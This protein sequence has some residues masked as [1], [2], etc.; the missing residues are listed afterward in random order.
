M[1]YKFTF[2]VFTPAFNNAHK[3]NRA[4]E[5]L[6]MQTFK[7]FEWLIVDDGSTDNTSEMIKK[8]QD[9]VHFP[10]HYIRQENRGKHIATNVGVE[11]AQGEFFVS[12]DS[13]DALPPNALERYKYYWDSIPIEQKHRYFQVTALAMHSTGG[14]ATDKY[15]L[16]VMDSHSLEMIYKY[17]IKGSIGHGCARTEILRMFPYPTDLKTKFVPEGLV[18]HA[19]AQAG[20]LERCVNEGLYIFYDDQDNHRLT[21]QSPMKFADS[22]ALWHRL[23]LNTEIKEWFLSAP[24]KITESS[25]HYT[26]FSL[27]SGKGLLEQYKAL[28]NIFAKLLWLIGLPIGLTVY[29]KDIMIYKYLEILLKQRYPVRFL[30]SR[31][32]RAIR[33]S[34]FFI[35][36]RNNYIL[37]FYS[38]AQSAAL[39]VDSSLYKDDILFYQNYLRDGDTVIDAG[40]NI[41]LLTLEASS[42][43]K[44]NGKVYAIE[45]HPRTYSYL[46]GNI[47]L[48]QKSNIVSFNYAVGDRNGK[49]LFQ[50]S[51]RHDDTNGITDSNQGIQVLIKRLDDLPIIESKI[52]LLKIDVE[53]YEL[54]VLRGGKKL[55]ERTACIYFESWE[56][57]FSKYHYTC[58]DLFTF[59]LE[60]KFKIFKIKDDNRLKQIGVEYVST[61]CENLIAIKDTKSFA[62]HTKLRLL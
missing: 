16:D 39:W 33:I 57:H 22:H 18:V 6:K 21:K 53:G 61:V 51:N 35:I 60:Q 46:Q 44:D 15:P 56:Q 20:Y 28:D 38:S 11:K 52:S 1:A 19:I 31:I 43:I 24:I 17:K 10:I 26:R 49:I 7:D 45:A 32:L 58:K 59:L 27:H 34:K 4:Y 37:R 29:I 48:N 2:T 41:G 50:N 12:V 30:L 3:L 55:L 8:Y 47:K 14:L 23:I 36:K 40:A 62:Y 9:E 13:D 42:I 54:F 25:V 5:S